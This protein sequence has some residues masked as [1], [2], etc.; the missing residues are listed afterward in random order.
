M[1][2]TVKYVIIGTIAIAGLAA[3]SLS[4]T[5]GLGVNN[6]SLEKSRQIMETVVNTEQSGL[7]IRVTDV[8]QN[9]TVQTTEKSAVTP[10]APLADKETEEIEEVISGIVDDRVVSVA[11]IEGN[12]QN[13]AIVVGERGFG[14]HI[15][16]IQRGMNTIL[17]VTRENIEDS[18]YN[19]VIIEHRVKLDTN[20]ETSFIGFTPSV[21]FGFTNI[22][23]T[24]VGFAR[25]VD[26]LNNVDTDEVRKAA[27]LYVPPVIDLHNLQG[28]E[29]CPE[30]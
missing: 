30:C 17:K 8:V 24:S 23:N 18:Y 19:M 5:G 9:E 26:D 27:E 12:T 16:V 15:I 3:L 25:V 22:A 10:Q 6:D 11:T 4:A 14:E 1:K 13:V 29:P 7:G 21:D 2:T 28:K 20:R